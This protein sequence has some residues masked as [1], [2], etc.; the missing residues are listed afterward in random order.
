MG[1]ALLSSMFTG[2]S[3][4]IW[5]LAFGTI[6]AIPQY[7]RTHFVLVDHS[8]DKSIDRIVITPSVAQTPE[9]PI[10]FWK[11]ITEPASTSTFTETITSTVIGQTAPAHLYSNT[12]TITDKDT[13]IV[14]STSTSIATVTEMLN[15]KG[16][17]ERAAWYSSSRDK[18]PTRNHH[19]QR[20]VYSQEHVAQL[21]CL[22]KLASPRNAVATKYAPHCKQGS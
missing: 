1:S 19:V 11:T 21:Q 4:L 18:T 15:H 17:H 16:V 10:I 3:R 5:G 14:W 8:H 9:Q 6:M 2:G 22:T 12:T 20:F 7:S 13:S